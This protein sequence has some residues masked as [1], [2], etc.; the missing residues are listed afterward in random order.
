M[1]DGLKAWHEEREQE[2]YDR[3]ANIIAGKSK[4]EL[5]DKIEKAVDDLERMAASD[6]TLTRLNHHR[7]EDALKTLKEILK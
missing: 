5:V 3:K 1:S 6:P 4:Y 2:D 7:L